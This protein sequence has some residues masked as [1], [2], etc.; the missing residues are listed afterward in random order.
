[1][2]VF[3]TIVFDLGVWKAVLGIVLIALAV[4][5][6]RRTV[7]PIAPVR[8]ITLVSLRVLGFVLLLL[9]VLNPVSVSLKSEERS[10]L[11]VALFDMSRS[12]GVRDHE[13]K[14]RREEAEAFLRRF[15]ASLDE[16]GDAE[17]AIVPFASDLA[18]GPVVLDSIPGASGD[19][20]DIL[21]A[22]EEAQMRFRSHNLAGIVLLSDGRISRGMTNT[23][24]N[25]AAPVFTVGFGDT[26]EGS[27]VAI[28]RIRYD[29][30]AYV[31]TAAGI[32]G[33][34]RSTGFIDAPVRVQLEENG[35]VL[36]GEELYVRDGSAELTARLTFVPEAAGDRT[37]TVRVIP[38]AGDG[39]EENN[40][41]SI[42]VRVLKQ[43]LRVAY[44]DQFADWNATFIM[45]IARR[46]QRFEIEAV[47]W[48]PERGFIS[49]PDRRPWK[50]PSRAAEFERYDLIIVADDSRE[51]A[52]AGRIEALEAYIAGGGGFLLIA[53]ENSPLRSPGAATLIGTVL[54]VT[55]RGQVMVETGEFFVTPSVEIPEHPLAAIFIEHDGAG[56]LPPLTARLTNC[57]V[58]AGA[59]MPLALNDGNETF[60][61]CAVQRKGK[62][63][64]AVVLGFPL[65]RWRLAGDGGGDFYQAFI[66][67][68]IQYL[69][70]GFDAPDLDLITDRSAYRMGDRIGLT[71]YAREGRAGDGVRGEVV[72]LQ[73]G[74]ETVV[75]TFLFE[76]EP[77][78]DGYYRAVLEAL[79]PGQYR[80][81][82][83]EVR[84]GG[85]GISAETS[86]SVQPMSV[87]FLRTSRDS[88]FLRYVADVSGGGMIETGDPE[89]L[90][91]RLS[92]SPDRVERR[93]ADPLRQSLPLFMGIVLAFA[94]EWV[95]RKVWGLV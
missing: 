9:F 20:T 53:D 62:G 30:I 5:L 23:P 25:I 86:V 29:R 36:D 34:V 85:R 73:E 92:L 4:Y 74:R 22:I 79:Q 47:T 6:Y 71:V 64:T 19:G 80:I 57:A 48:L 56:R 60:P 43:K 26:L 46:S 35:T 65:W 91:H 54:P 2:P 87:E 37:L 14:S 38:P 77:R 12:M 50:S 82:A 45:D 31:G 81:A 1:M 70:E 83:T 93:E 11:V 88:D 55:P 94:V 61:F 76:P 18:P 51:F 59:E 69:A 58:N 15:K 17:L 67:G 13:G 27:D 8:R 21:R 7:P 24:M 75:R 40:E 3:S 49:L 44:I 16:T 33:I 42:T 90:A 66:G 39:R 89:S 32:E 52:P 28:E 84:D 41:E 10:P 72:R 63:V 78:R 68:L 95:L